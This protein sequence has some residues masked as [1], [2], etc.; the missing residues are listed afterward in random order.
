MMYLGQDAIGLVK[1][2]NKEIPIYSNTTFGNIWTIYQPTDVDF[3]NNAII[4]TD[5]SGI[6]TDV[7]AYGTAALL[8]K[9]SLSLQYGTIPTELYEKTQIKNIGNNKV[10]FYTGG[11]NSSL[12][13]ITNTDC[14]D[15]SKAYIIYRNSNTQPSRPEITNFINGHITHIK[16][17]YHGL[18]GGASGLIAYDANNNMIKGSG[19]GI[20]TTQKY[21]AFMGVDANGTVY[22]GSDLDSYGDII[23]NRG[24]TYRWPLSGSVYGIYDLWFWK[25]NTFGGSK[26]KINFEIFSVNTGKKTN[27]FK[28]CYG[29]GLGYTNT[30]ISKI[31]FGTNSSSDWIGPESKLEAWDCGPIN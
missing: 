8:L 9:P 6:S 18:L 23:G 15:L 26:Y 19:Y 29:Q 7:T 3:E 31:Q 1:S 11:T 10:Q 20:S 14:I 5:A 27:A 4:L 24:L 22:G 30:C 21:C 2:Y 28:I 25:D 17:T 16:L 13:T 12:V